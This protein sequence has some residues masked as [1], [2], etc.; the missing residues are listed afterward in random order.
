MMKLFWAKR[1][2]AFRIAW[3]LEESGV[4]YERVVVDLGDPAAKDA[5]A[6]RAV[7][8]M[9]KVPAIED[10]PAHLCDSGAIAIYLAD[11]Y[12]ESRLA[13]PVGHADRARFLQWVTFTN[14]TVEPA[15]LEKLVKLESKPASYGWGSFDLMLGTL[16][17]GL[18][19]GAWILGERFSAADVLLGT[20]ASF[21]IQ[22]GLVKDDSV[23]SDYVGR[24]QAR[25]AWQRAQGFDAD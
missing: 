6:F 23:F 4:A 25:S 18:T 5:P 24:C 1:T 15:M 11:Q 7:S 21:L 12:P 22:F 20:S 17:T 3:L 13:P 14:S 19:K 2:R 8:P 16:R 9:G 10:G